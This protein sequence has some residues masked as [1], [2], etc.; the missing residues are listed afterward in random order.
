MPNFYPHNARDFE[1][2]E[3]KRDFYLLARFEMGFWWNERYVAPIGK[4]R[5]V[6]RPRPYV[7]EMSGHE[8]K[9]DNGNVC[10]TSVRPKSPRRKPRFVGMPD[11][12]DKPALREHREVLQRKAAAKKAASLSHL[13]KSEREALIRLRRELKFKFR[14][15]D[16][17]EVEEQGGI[18]NVAMCAGAVVTFL[19]ARA[20]GRG[21]RACS[22]VVE[23]VRHFVEHATSIWNKLKR[24]SVL[25]AMC[26]VTFWLFHKF[27]D[28]AGGGL[29]VFLRVCGWLAAAVPALAWLKVVP[30]AFSPLQE[31][32]EEHSG[33][34]K[35]LSTAILAL[36]LKRC[37][38]NRKNPLWVVNDL[39]NGL[40]AVDQIKRSD[41]ALLSFFEVLQGALNGVLGLFGARVSFIE[42]NKGGLAAW[43]A[44][45]DVMSSLYKTSKLDL[46]PTEID[47][48]IKLTAEGYEH[49]K[50]WRDVADVNRDITKYLDVLDTMMLPI[51][52]AISSRNNYRIEPLLI[53]M[54]GEPGIGKTK[55]TMAIAS[56][57]LKKG[58]ILPASADVN[59]VS[60][61]IFQKGTS[62]FW[63]GYSGQGVFIMDDAFQTRAAAS[64]EENDYY[65]LIRAISCWSMPLDMADIESKGRVFFS[66][67]AVL[68]SSN[69]NSIAS[70]ASNLVTCP[71][72]VARRLANSVRLHL[73]PEY[74]TSDGFL[75]IDKFN[76][77]VR[78]CE[79]KK[80]LSAYPWY[81]WQVSR[82]NFLTGFSDD[83]R[84]PLRDFV[85]E[86]CATM[87][88][89]LSNH[90]K[91]LETMSKFVDAFGLDEEEEADGTIEEVEFSFTGVHEHAG[92][93]L[94]Y[95]DVASLYYSTMPVV[96]NELEG[97]HH[98]SIRLRG[99]RIWRAA[100]TAYARV[101][102]EVQHGYRVYMT[103]IRSNLWSLCSSGD[104][105]ESAVS[106]ILL[107]CLIT[108]LYRGIKLI[109]R[110]LSLPF[111]TKKSEEHAGDE[112]P[113]TVD[114]V[115][116]C[117]GLQSDDVIS[118]KL[119]RNMYKL[120]TIAYGSGDIIVKSDSVGHV[121]SITDGVA[122][123][124][125]H[126]V[127]FVE[128]FCAAN[129]D[130]RV[131]VRFVSMA[132]PELHR[133]ISTS[134]WKSCLEKQHAFDDTDLTFV[135][136]HPYITCRKDIR[137][138][139]IKEDSLRN[140]GGAD[141]H[142][143]VSRAI[144]GKL[145][146]V[147]FG[148]SVAVHLK[149][150]KYDVG[151]V[152]KSAA[153]HLEYSAPVRSGDCG[154][155]ITL[156]DVRRSGGAIAL[157]LH[158]GGRVGVGRGLGVVVTQEMVQ[159][160][161]TT[162]APVIDDFEADARK[163]GFELQNGGDMRLNT[164]SF[165]HLGSVPVPVSSPV[166][167]RLVRNPITFERFGE[168][169]K[170]PAY[171]R[172]FVDD[173][174]ERVFPMMKALDKYANL[175]VGA[176]VPDLLV[177]THVAMS[178]FSALTLHHPRRLLSFEESVVGVPELE[179]RSVTRGTSA[180]FPFVLSS[181]GAGKT[182]FFGKDDQF[183]L[184][185]PKAIELRLRVEDIIAKAA[186]GVR[187]AHVYR[188]FLKDETRKHSKV[189]AGE[190][191]LIS[192]AALDYVLAWR[193]MFGAFQS[194]VFKTRVDSG[195]APGVNPYSEWNRVAYNLQ[196]CGRQCFDGDFAAYDA[197]ESPEVHAALLNYINSWYDDGATNARI[198]SVLWR[199]L[200][201]SR[202]LGGLEPQCD[203]LYQ[204]TKGM[205]SG[206]PFTTI[207]NSMYCLV[208]MA[209][210]YQK[211]TGRITT[212][213]D[214]CHVV[215]YGD[216]NVT[217][218]CD[219]VA[220]V[221]NQATV[222]AAVKELFGY[223]Y[224]SSRKDGSLMTT[225][226][227]ESLSFLK[228]GFR[229]EAGVWRAPLELDSCL[230]SMYWTSARGTAKL[231]AQTA[232]DLDAAQRELSLHPPEVW[233]TYMPTIQEIRKDIGVVSRLP[234]DRAATR[235]FV[236]TMDSPW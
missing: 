178:K 134:K 193:M 195:M 54:V 191:R 99:P 160:A 77:E 76:A 202:H 123:M 170:R 55:L 214:D 169:H 129:E 83:K 61:Q 226:P 121:V 229:L 220:P 177:V 27:A 102:N 179:I 197:G 105:A 149:P 231:R 20:L 153:R 166:V 196:R 52:G 4:K 194:A 130:S 156:D 147:R 173:S 132:N 58:G 73:K 28:H 12:S 95:E 199:D 6:E 85:E 68:L 206:H 217:N 141:V 8:S 70:E 110:M 43:K 157:G 89:K 5:Q 131:F 88:S 109:F 98:T 90:G 116:P 146:R 106:F 82:H 207:V 32:V 66:S 144:D 219:A 143:D 162:L 161:L 138:Y 53:G 114:V 107:Y 168:N 192:S 228:R 15:D 128:R 187:L 172:P 3:C 122:A 9:D 75:D 208:V 221:F 62:K 41:D 21:K 80:G 35:V 181:T 201:N 2:A 145:E 48:L 171:L 16:M 37:F 87:R 56:A 175:D 34:T 209:S 120:Y 31:N 33:T 136:F 18:Q 215:T 189:D 164:G 51:R 230:R 232:D 81:M 184:S 113:K 44:S 64:K 101:L 7:L 227:I 118:T 46:G 79:A 23:S 74:A 29:D 1:L 236:T 163:Q 235:D 72:A 188:D 10:F 183:D 137:K 22:A 233:E 124:P 211:C 185:T 218:V 45:V 210:A 60:A 182:D 100:V 47:Q 17:P 174:G 234:C 30:E 154:G 165:V 36:V 71:E 198:R 103:S 212:F 84:I 200:V 86:C 150:F 19:A 65:M 213:W 78:R 42:R 140:V 39:K 224:T 125:R 142:L 91:D 216:D 127:S 158:F 186:D 57:L 50:R 117:D 69:L 176:D 26:G 148:S 59:D 96:V 93:E 139:W 111:R 159:Q 135:D 13:S 108:T 92:R 67:K 222:A 24:M 63:A 38:S 119:Y 167:S 11:L 104:V 203:T 155:V 225:V 115:P 151:G 205:P 14:L 223:E 190:T 133:E 94:E 204:W 180:G 25:C 49:K 112:L 40:S 152:I 97:E 126:Y